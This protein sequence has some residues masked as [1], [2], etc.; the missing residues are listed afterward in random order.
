MLGH[1][2]VEIREKLG[3]VA[4][5]EEAC[6]WRVDSEVSKAHVRPSFSPLLLPVDSDVELSIT[7]SAAC[8][9]LCRH[10]SHHDK[11]RLNL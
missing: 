1:W 8:L 2:G 9:P 11:N 3:V 6:H 7:P 10:V 5:L 4:L